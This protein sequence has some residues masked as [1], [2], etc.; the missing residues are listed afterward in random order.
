MAPHKDQT[1]PFRRP[2]LLLSVLALLALLVH[3]AQHRLALQTIAGVHQHEVVLIGDSHGDDLPW[4][5]RPRFTN[6][7]QD[8]FTAHQYLEAIIDTR[9]ED[10]RLRVVVLTVW[11]HKFGPL[12]MDRMSGAPQE[13][14]WDQQA[15]GKIAPLLDFS[16]FLEPFGPRRLR[17]RAALHSLQM[18]KVAMRFDQDCIE[19]AVDSTFRRG[20]G[21]EFM[22][23]HWWPESAETQEI[24]ERFADQVLAQGWRLIVLENPLHWHY[25]DQIHAPSHADYKSFL[26]ALDNRP[27]IT[28]LALGESGAPHTFFRDW[29][30]LT[31]EGEA[32][33]GEQLE[34]ALAAEIP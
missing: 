10:S 7:A 9:P 16:D 6:P 27:G 18:K 30:H 25:L 28:V 8:L 31:C 3:T 23:T 13:D 5:G 1:R 14:G 15:L 29:H 24:V 2:L 20:Q 22:H 17:W 34:L 11:P 32:F 19:T 26:A 4:P 33:V 21:Y 12:A